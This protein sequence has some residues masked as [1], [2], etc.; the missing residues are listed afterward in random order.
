MPTI[1]IGTYQKAP[2]QQKA[3]M[4]ASGYRYTDN[5]VVSQ[6]QQ[7][8]MRPLPPPSSYRAGETEA[9]LSSRVA[10]QREQE[11]ITA[12]ELA[13]HRQLARQSFAGTFTPSSF[14]M[15]QAK[16]GESVQREIRRMPIEKQKIQAKLK[17]LQSPTAQWKSEEEFKKAVSGVERFTPE[18]IE[19]KGTIVST[20]A[21]KEE[22]PPTFQLPIFA[23]QKQ[24]YK[25]PEKRYYVV[26]YPRGFG[27]IGVA[28]EYKVGEKFKILGLIPYGEPKPGKLYTSDIL[29]FTREAGDIKEENIRSAMKRKELR[30]VSTTDI[31]LEQLSNMILFSPFIIKSPYAAY[32]GE[33]KLKPISRHELKL[34]PPKQKVKPEVIDLTKMSESD[35]SIVG[36]I[37]STYKTRP[38]YKVSVAGK[39]RAQITSS[40]RMRRMGLLVE[41]KTSLKESS[42]LLPALSMLQRIRQESKTKYASDLLQRTKQQSKTIQLYKPVSITRTK[43]TPAYKL[44]WPT[45]TKTAFVPKYK[46][47]PQP[48]RKPLL[49][50]A[51]LVIT[52][53]MPIINI[54]SFEMSGIFEA[55]NKRKVIIK[56]K[57]IV[58]RMLSLKDLFGK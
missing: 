5:Y 19:F 50:K 15:T 35:I 2:E 10:A 51:P 26:K 23:E 14:A 20:E 28:Q 38:K 18:R 40:E 7:P 45:L 16:K 17:L 37:K 13:E 57:V 6:T 55:K 21:M 54:P 44:A 9:D 34:L 36:L 33:K 48:T 42:V 56:E 11:A 27:S 31:K 49:I 4:Y 47:Q 58:T 43:Q 22:R 46:V 1:Y 29:G 25:A 30:G 24:F 3:L 53:R 32:F 8:G 41:S 12:R 52:P 39:S